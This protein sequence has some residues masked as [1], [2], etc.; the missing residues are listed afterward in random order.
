MPCCEG[1]LE[2]FS[3]LAKVEATPL[4]ATPKAP[5]EKFDPTI[6]D[7]WRAEDLGV[8]ES[9]NIPKQDT[10]ADYDKAVSRRLAP[11]T[12]CPKSSASEEA[13][14]LGGV[15]K[16]G[17]GR[18]AATSG[19]QKRELARKDAAISTIVQR[20]DELIAEKKALEAKLAS[21]AKRSGS[22]KRNI[23]I[24]ALIG[25]IGW[26]GYDKYRSSQF[27]DFTIRQQMANP[28]LAKSMTLPV[29]PEM[30]GIGT[31]KFVPVAQQMPYAD[32]ETIQKFLRMNNGWKVE[33][34]QCYDTEN[35]PVVELH[36][37]DPWWDSHR[38]IT[39][40][41]VFPA[42]I[43]VYLRVMHKEDHRD[44]AYLTSSD[45]TDPKNYP[46]AQKDMMRMLPLAMLLSP[47]THEQLKSIIN[48]RPIA[49]DDR[50]RVVLLIGPCGTSERM[51]RVADDDY[52]MYQTHG[53][54]DACYFSDNHAEKLDRISCF[55][56][57]K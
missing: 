29:T 15:V 23:L 7:I 31:E 17:N 24:V 8:E 34:K 3:R 6:S 55:D 52:A 18:L 25:A 45:F 27:E 42:S 33:V 21:A 1:G 53:W 32:E 41:H 5:E 11:A 57:A 13:R 19:E 20:K 38:Q 50:A 56:W 47:A 54:A 22:M 48:M 49:K 28:E 14:K 39:L 4:P 43:D 35:D 44:N 46:M 2:G 51:V 36:A 9:E 16:K 12:Q 10:M 40:L 30:E 26:L 37:I